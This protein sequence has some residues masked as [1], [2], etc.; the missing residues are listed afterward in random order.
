MTDD[1]DLP[2]LPYL[3][4]LVDA[5]DRDEVETLMRAYARAAL[6]PLLAEI[7]RLHEEHASAYMHGT[8]HLRERAEKAER[9]LSEMRPDR[10]RCVKNMNDAAE[11]NDELRAR[12]E[13]CAKHFE[14]GPDTIIYRREVAAA[15]R[16]ITEQRLE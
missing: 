12:L 16:R 7:E 1:A 14:D 3:G 15:I 6:A 13:M 10:D 5:D 11:R 8:E 4:S 2:P 9:E